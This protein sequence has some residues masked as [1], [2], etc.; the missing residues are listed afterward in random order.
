MSHDFDGLFS[1]DDMPGLETVSDGLDVF[2][3]LPSYQRCEE[4]LPTICFRTGEC[5]AEAEKPRTFDDVNGPNGEGIEINFGSL[6]YVHIPPTVTT[7]TATTESSI[8]CAWD[9][10]DSGAS[11]HMSPC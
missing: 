11:H 5:R 4:K 9:M 1:D 7:F 8:K 3:W 10:Y 6:E 2:N